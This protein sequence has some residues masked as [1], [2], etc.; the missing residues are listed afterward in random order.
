[1]SSRIACVLTLTIFACVV[2]KT[3]TAKETVKPSA[4]ANHRT[5]F[6]SSSLENNF[7]KQVSLAEYKDS[8]VIVL[9]FLG[10]EC[11]MAKLYGPTLSR[12]Q[13]EFKTKGVQFLGISSNKQDS[14]TE[15]TA[16]VNRYELS[17]PMLKDLGN[18]VADKLGAKRTPEVFVL[19]SSLDVCYQGRID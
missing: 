6:E 3:G 7:G 14:L 11:P 5:L 2:A 17:F 15:L 10:T 12:L 13:D 1:M 18:K 9:A 16:Y 4:T 8:K 19:D